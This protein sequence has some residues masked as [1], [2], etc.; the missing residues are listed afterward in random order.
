[1]SDPLLTSEENA[2]V[3]TFA[4]AKRAAGFRVKIGSA[5][6]TWMNVLG[7][8]GAVIGWVRGVSLCV[9]WDKR[10]ELFKE[11]RFEDAAFFHETRER[12]GVQM[13]GF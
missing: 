8:D 2:E 9:S 1:M 6:Q 4:A 12:W 5:S 3:A 13:P 10:I 11:W 7:N